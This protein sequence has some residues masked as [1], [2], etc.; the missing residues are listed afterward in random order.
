MGAHRRI[1]DHRVPERAGI[2]RHRVPEQAAKAS[3][4]PRRVF[5]PASEAA[6]IGLKVTE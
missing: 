2:S 1:S 6:G 4:S 3:V 5:I